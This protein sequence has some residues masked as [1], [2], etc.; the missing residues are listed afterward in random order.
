MTLTKDQTADAICNQTG[1]PKW[2]SAELVDFA[3]EIIKETLESGEDIFIYL[4]SG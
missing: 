1:I 3:F 2:R 4:S